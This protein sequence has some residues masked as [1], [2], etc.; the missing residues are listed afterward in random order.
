MP[1]S[2]VPDSIPRAVAFDLDGTLVDPKEGIV[3]CF[4][5]ALERLDVESPDHEA[6]AKFIGPSLQTAFRTL[7]ASDDPQLVDKAVSIYRERFA[8]SGIFENNVYPG[9]PEMLD[10]LRASGLQLFVATSKPTNYARKILTQCGIASYFRQIHGSEMD[11]TRADKDELI[12]HLLK[13]EK[14]KGG[15]LVMVGDRKHDI[16]G[17]HAHGVRAVGVLWGYGSFEELD[18]AGADLYCRT[19]GDLPGMLIS[20]D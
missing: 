11:G 18:E 6:L 3:A 5:Y 20:R 7:L 10:A 9:I 19:P 16:A 14:M 8:V 2:S 15:E 4:E 17:A 12:A 13:H 1:K